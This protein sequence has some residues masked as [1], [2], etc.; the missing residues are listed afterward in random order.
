MDW[1][2]GLGVGCLLIIMAGVW[3]IIDKLGTIADHLKDIQ[4][5]TYKTQQRL[6]SPDDMSYD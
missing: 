4:Y 6:K 5:N 3:R 2:I 1:A